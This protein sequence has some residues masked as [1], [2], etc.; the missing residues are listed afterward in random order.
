MPLPRGSNLRERYF[1]QDQFDEGG[2]VVCLA[3]DETTHLPV[4]L[5]DSLNLS[6]QAELLAT[7]RRPNLP[8]AT[9]P[10]ILKGR[11]YLAG[12]RRRPRHE[13]TRCMW[14]CGLRTH[15][16]IHLLQGWH[17]QYAP[18]VPFR[19]FDE[20]VLRT[21]RGLRPHP[22][23]LAL[24]PERTRGALRRETAVDTSVGGGEGEDLKEAGGPSAPRLLQDLTPPPARLPPG[25][26]HTRRGRGQGWGWRTTAAVRHAPLARP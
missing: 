11:Q 1:I 18:R 24:D 6:P 2:G 19:K 25:N 14:G 26:A 8:R 21:L 10:F 5:K 9:D 16:P 7:L 13:K 3:F 17:L 22:L 12:R 4:A 15:T 20:E 23:P